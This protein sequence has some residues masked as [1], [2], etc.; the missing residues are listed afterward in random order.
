MS[1]KKNL[2][3]DNI[4]LRLQAYRQKKGLTGKQLADIIGISQGSLSELENGKRDPSGKVFQG[5]MENTDIDISWLITGKHPE[6]LRNK[7][8]QGRKFEIL[9]QVEEWLSEVVDNKEEKEE[10]AGY[11]DSSST[12]KVA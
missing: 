5:I 9:N 4:G 7:T 11:K 1:N 10:S 8:C 2:E 6:K 12:R 3:T